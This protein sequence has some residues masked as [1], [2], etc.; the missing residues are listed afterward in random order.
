MVGFT[1][2]R[3]GAVVVAVVLDGVVSTTAFT[4]LLGNWGPNCRELG[5]WLSRGR[6]D[7]QRRGCS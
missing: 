1:P 3:A 7:L 2:S 6:H 5:C 4:I